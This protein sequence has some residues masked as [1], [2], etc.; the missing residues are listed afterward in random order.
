MR[1]IIITALAASTVLAQ[2]SFDHPGI[3]QLE[4]EL[5]ASDPLRFEKL[6]SP[7]LPR[8]LQQR[9]T[10]LSK[11]VLGWH[12]YWTDASAY[13]SFDYSALTHIAYF[14]YETDTA[15]GGYKTIR[16]WQ[17]TPLIDYAH[18]RGVKVLLTVTN[19]GYDQNDKILGDTVKQNT[20]I[21]T[22]ISLLTQRNGDGVNFD[23][24]SV[25][26][27]QRANLVSFI[28][29][30]S[31][32]IHSALAGSEISMASP[33][34]DWSGSWDLAQLSTLCDYLVLMGYDYYWS[35]S[36]T[37]GPVA[38]LQGENYNVS[39]SITTYLNSGVA[40]GRLMLGVPWYGYDW[41][42][43]SSAR[44]DAARGTAT[45]RTYA[46]AE[47][48]AATYGMTFDAATSIP[49]IAYQDPGGWRQL[50]YDDSLSLAMKFNYVSTRGIAGIGIWALGY[51]NKLPGPWQAIR[52]AFE[53]TD[54]ALTPSN[55]PQS[56]RLEQNY[57][58]PFNSET[59]IEYTL[60][61]AQE[62]SLRVVD[63][64]G[65]QIVVLDEGERSAGR[66]ITRWNASN[67]ASGVYYLQLWA[68]PNVAVRP[69]IL[70]R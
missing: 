26:S 32:R 22:L 12:P 46:A 67:N 35:G 14:S 66:H 27:T 42:V 13:L 8:P 56:F 23:F 29:R 53:T 18:A 44:K 2:G 50:W 58:N 40:P 57:P 37:A 64:L 25:R 52:N 65:R 1:L 16:S 62:V 49:W 21:S 55:Q 68:G 6:S 63:V 34:V 69:L 45:S 39:R 4:S 3:H 70:L 48:M 36:S 33:A 30:A 10:T 31:D 38:P 60:T 47:Q 51:D 43:Q 59:V 19:F 7:G 11:R 5:H 41:P 54:I 15:T 20:M 17:T 28:R 9:T 24:E 61:D